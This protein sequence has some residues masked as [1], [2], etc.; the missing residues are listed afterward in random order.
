[1]AFG[2]ASGMF[3]DGFPNLAA[4]TLP[5]PPSNKVRKV[6]TLEQF[7]SVRDCASDWLKVAMDIGLITLQRRGDLVGMKYTDIEGDR[8]KVITS[9]TER[10][11]DR[12]FLKIK[13]GKDLAEAISQ[14]RRL[15]PV[16]PFLIHRAPRIKKEFEGQE[17][18]AQVRDQELTKEFR[19]A[20]DATGLFNDCGTGEAPTFA[21]IRV[22]GSSVYIA[23]G[24]PKEYVNLLMGHTTQRM[25]D[26]YI[27]QQT[28][29][30]ECAAELN[31]R[32]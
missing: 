7:Y 14:S 25:T 6:L 3:P 24:Y 8:L 18:W 5:A 29:W 19:R 32:G 16:S 28:N 13:I 17:H 1:M 23:Q 30:T 31:L 12:A 10:H 9:K 27:G 22:L 4:S 26:S 11:G 15:P 21:E 2:I 20:R